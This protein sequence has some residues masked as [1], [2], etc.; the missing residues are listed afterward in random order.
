L[1]SSTTNPKPIYSY[2]DHSP[3]TL[4]QGNTTKNGNVATKPSYWDQVIGSIIEM[5]PKESL[6]ELQPKRLLENSLQLLSSI[7]AGIP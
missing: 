1:A 7:G 6:Y 4:V 3:F 2:N 5:S